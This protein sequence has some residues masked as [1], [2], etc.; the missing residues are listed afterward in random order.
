MVQIFQT[1]DVSDAEPV[2]PEIVPQVTLP[3]PDFVPLEKYEQLQQENRRLKA[4]L[5]SMVTLQVYQ[6]L[7]DEN[8]ELKKELKQ[9]RIERNRSKSR[10]E[11]Y[12]KKLQQQKNGESLSKKAKHQ[13]CH[14]ML[15]K[16]LSPT[17][18]ECLIKDQKKSTKWDQ[19]GTLILHMLS[20][21]RSI[22]FFTG[23]L[24]KSIF[25]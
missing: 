25:V 1:M 10:S 20:L 16:K 22:L 13:V 21:Y 9:T 24:S 4:Q 7:L 18:V 14:E 19:K 12:A 5:E 23:H 8:T 6:D 2:Q 3:N 11:K 15:D 17:T